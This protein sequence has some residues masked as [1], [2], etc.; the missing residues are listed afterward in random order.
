MKVSIVCDHAGAGLANIL[1][2]EVT[3]NGCELV[4]LA[5]DI[6]FDD[7]PDAAEVMA[8][9]VISGNTGRGILVCGSGV[10]VAVAANKF[11]GIRAAVCHD[12]YS[13]HQGVEHDR[14]NILCLGARIIGEE[15][16]KEIAGIFFR[17]QPSVEE[18]HIRRSEKIDSIEK[19]YFK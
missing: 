4:P 14:M 13:A 18:R 12:C 16:A 15:P 8:Q 11:P 6:V 9:A 5:P 10:G 7:Y 19:K 17:A 1:K 2:N 3:K